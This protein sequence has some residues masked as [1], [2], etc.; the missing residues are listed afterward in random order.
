MSLTCAAGETRSWSLQCSLALPP[1]VGRQLVCSFLM[2]QVF[3]SSS[4]PAKAP[5][6]LSHWFGLQRPFGTA[7]AVSAR[8]LA[9]PIAGMLNSAFAH[10]QKDR[11]AAH[12]R[13]SYSKLVGLCLLLPTSPSPLLPHVLPA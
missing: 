10:G 1:A 8:D 6:L 7:S 11:G 3:A 4:I 2:T 9:Q 12:A 5:E 13:V